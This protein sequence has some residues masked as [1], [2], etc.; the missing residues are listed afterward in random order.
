[1]LT[2]LVSCT[3]SH[4]PQRGDLMKDRIIFVLAAALVLA[5]VVARAQSVARQLPGCSG[6]TA[7][8]RISTLT[9][10]M[11]QFEA[12]VTAHRK[13]YRDR[14]INFNQQRTVP[15]YKMADS[16]IVVDAA[17]VMTI[18]T[19]PPVTNPPRDAAWEAFTK[20]YAD[21][22]KVTSQAIVC[23]PKAF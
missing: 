9:G 11:A 6:I 21:V 2:S 1:L 3:F 4:A 14:G 10:S 17:Q 13:W 19:S 18:H 5:P 12:A 20:M 7:I 15:I 23:M 16:T 8:V 22:S